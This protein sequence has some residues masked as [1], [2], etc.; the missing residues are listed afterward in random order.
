[1]ARVRVIR[2][3]ASERSALALGVAS[4]VTGPTL[5]A[6]STTL[7]GGA[8][9][10]AGHDLLGPAPGALAQRATGSADA[11]EAMIHRKAA[12]G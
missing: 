7:D 10:D 3:V 9:T 2:A 12:P 11:V 8:A 1:M 5:L 6:G 4:L